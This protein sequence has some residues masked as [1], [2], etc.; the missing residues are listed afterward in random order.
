MR[1]TGC[2]ECF[3]FAGFSL[4]VNERNAVWVGILEDDAFTFGKVGKL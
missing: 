1:F 3:S 2:S 4:A